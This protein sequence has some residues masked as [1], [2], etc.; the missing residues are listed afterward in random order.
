MIDL[1]TPATKEMVLH[2]INPANERWFGHWGTHF[3]CMDQ[4]FDLN[5]MILPGIF[6]DVRSV[7]NRDIT[8][9]D[10]DLSRIHGKMFIGFYTGWIEKNAYGTNEY[11]G[12]HPQLSYE[13][14]DTLLARHVGII[15]IDAAGVRRGAEHTPIDQ[16]CADKG[17]FIVEN[18]CQLGEL[19]NLEHLEI[20]TVPMKLSGATGL[21]CRV[22]ARI[23][24]ASH[25]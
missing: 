6:F 18:L 13:L 15:G 4:E 20:S 21:P 8:M 5:Y 3:D 9:E 25:E 17:V 23:I 14:I 10:I 22:L 1:T 7:E 16:K 24:S 12:D 19:V 2:T 11:F